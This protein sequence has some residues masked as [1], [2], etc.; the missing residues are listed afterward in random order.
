VREARLVRDAWAIVP[1]KPLSQAKSRLAP[2]LAPDERAALSR[3]MLRDVLVAL[4]TAPELAGVALLAPP[5]MAVE[6]AAEFGCRE[7]GEDRALGFDA[8]LERAAARLAGA[9]AAT[10]VI[11]PADLPTL[12]AADVGALLAAHAGGV[13]VA[14]AA[15]DGGTNALVMTPPAAG[16]CRFG[17]DS[18][19]RHVEA[20]LRGG[21]AGVRLGLAGFARDIDTVDDVRW[22]CAQPGGSAAQRYLQATGIC[23]RLATRTPADT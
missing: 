6:L 8:N 12:T 9:G 15:A 11:V 10:V 4:T 1:V 13:T 20:A 21:V 16:R 22:L 5:G 7:I 18:A 14:E 19:R 23:A 17:P 3:C 2:V